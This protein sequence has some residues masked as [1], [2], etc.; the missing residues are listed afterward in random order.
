MANAACVRAR[1]A[2]LKCASVAKKARKTSAVMP[3]AGPA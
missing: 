2:V 3:S 1:L